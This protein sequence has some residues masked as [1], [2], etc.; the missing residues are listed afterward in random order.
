MIKCLLGLGDPSDVDGHPSHR[1]QRNFVAGSAYVMS[2][3][4]LEMLGCRL[5]GCKT[6]KPEVRPEGNWEDVFLSDHLRELGVEAFD[7]RDKC[8]GERFHPFHP[9][10]MP[11]SGSMGGWYG[12][13]SYNHAKGLGCCSVEPLSFHTFDAAGLISWHKRV[14]SE[15][16]AIEWAGAKE[17]TDKY[18]M[19]RRR[20]S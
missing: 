20:K 15:T 11:S 16:K 5:S 14:L 1:K 6:G 19:E 12:E 17:A 10:H 2:R 13:Y 8:G 18:D 3:P 4:A 9:S 7:T